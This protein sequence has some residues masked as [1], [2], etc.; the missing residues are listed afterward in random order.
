[1]AVNQSTAVVRPMREAKP[2]PRRHPPTEQSLVQAASRGLKAL[3]ARVGRCYLDKAVEGELS[4]LLAKCD[5]RLRARDFEGANDHLDLF[6]VGVQ[7][8]LGTE[9]SL[10]V[11]FEL[12]DVA[13]L[14]VKRYIASPER[15]LAVAADYALKSDLLESFCDLPLAEMPRPI[16]PAGVEVSYRAMAETIQSFY[17][18]EEQ[19]EILLGYA[20]RI[21]DFA[22]KNDPADV[23]LFVSTLQEMRSFL[24]AMEGV[25]VTQAQANR[26]LGLIFF[27]AGPAAA[28]CIIPLTWK[29]QLL[30][31]L[32]AVVLGGIYFAFQSFRAKLAHSRIKTY[33]VDT[34]LTPAQ[35]GTKTGEEIGALD[36][37]ERQEVIDALEQQKVAVARSPMLSPEE[38]RAVQ[39]RIQAAID[40]L[41]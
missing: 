25:Y 41:R 13:L 14:D 21:A 2:A 16:D 30:I 5:E 6:I 35:V 15:T 23:Q 38:K 26:L 33:V 10:R 34:S 36:D 29:A 17:L 24:G 7:R 1:M 11:G 9:I 22:R 8:N 19:E 28:T 27:G 37:D 31:A 39:E 40:A 32:L 4:R 12:A 18:P 3:Q 20:D